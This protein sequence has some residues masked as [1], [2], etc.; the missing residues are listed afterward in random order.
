MVTMNVKPSR[1]RFWPSSRGAL[2]ATKDLLLARAPTAT[3][4]EWQAHRTEGAE[5]AGW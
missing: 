2:F 5:Q 3:A 1:W 4:S